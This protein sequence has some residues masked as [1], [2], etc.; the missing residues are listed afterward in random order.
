[1]KKDANGLTIVHRYKVNSTVRS[2]AKAA[3]SR[4]YDQATTKNLPRTIY[5][6]LTNRSRNKKAAMTPHVLN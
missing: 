3:T 4:W 1:M 2:T 5:A 6:V